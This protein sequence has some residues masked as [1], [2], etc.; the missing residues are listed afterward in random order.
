VSS[1]GAARPG[2]RLFSRGTWDVRVM[3]VATAQRA[4]GYSTARSVLVR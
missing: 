4:A 2:F 3:R 1:T